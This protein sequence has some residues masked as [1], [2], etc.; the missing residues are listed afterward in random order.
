MDKVAVKKSTMA[1]FYFVLLVIALIQVY[2]LFWV[3]TSSFKTGEQ[4]AAMPAYSL[5]RQLFIGN[6]QHALESDLIRYFFNSTV[7]AAL[8]MVCLVVLSSLAAFAISS[9][10][11]KQSDKLMSFFLFGL[12]IPV[13]TCLIPMFRIY[14]QIGIRNTYWALIVPQVGFGLP[15]C[16]Y[17]YKN[18][19]QRISFS[20]IEAAAID[21]AST[22]YVFMRIIF[23]M[24]K[25]TTVTILTFNFIYVWNEFTYANTFMT[26]NAMKTLPIGLNDFI[27][28]MGMVDWGATF[29][30]IVLSILP[31][32]LIYFLLNRQV[33]EGMSAGAIK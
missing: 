22:W 26:K 8:V 16:I 1:L 14:N 29:A 15:M 3:I 32:L 17:L 27:G 18:F 24:S 19:M 11:F 9:I 2:P 10:R 13:F 30:A 4:L 6:Y 20:L 7:V 5:P 23:P 31:T 28:Q 33:I 21:G 25:N 12:M